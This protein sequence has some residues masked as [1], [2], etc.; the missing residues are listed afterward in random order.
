MAEGRHLDNWIDGYVRYLENTESP[1]LFKKWVAVSTIAAVLRRKCYSQWMIHQHTYPNMFIVLVGPAAIG[2]G[3]S[4][5]PAVDLLNM[6]EVK[7][8]SQSVTLQALIDSMIKATESRIV[9]GKEVKESAITVFS[10]EFAV[11]VGRNNIELMNAVTDWFD[12]SS[13]WTYETKGR[14]DEVLHNVFINIIGATTPGVL[15]KSMN[16]EA[17]T[18]GFTSRVVMIFADRKSK[19]VPIPAA[20]GD[21]KDLFQKLTLDLHKINEMQGQF[22]FTEEVIDK[23]IDWYNEQARNPPF[24][25]STRLEEYSGRRAVQLQKLLMIVSA[26]RS[27]ELIVRGQDF[28]YALQL[29]EEAEEVMPNAFRGYGRNEMAQFIEIAMRE[30]E[31]VGLIYVKDFIKRH[32]S[33]INPE[34]MERII[35]TLQQMGFCRVVQKPTGLI[36]QHTPEGVKK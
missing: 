12:C 11:F 26:A 18:G 21:N 3:V 29:L 36:L 31:A 33:D 35:K 20:Y 17:I 10:Q 5:R 27:N 4:M 24:K 19:I 13:V 32:R 9:E 2:K 28:D 14:G 25:N 8:S 6:M 1:E 23:W 30:I 34:D 16:E 15:Q 22:R 7:V